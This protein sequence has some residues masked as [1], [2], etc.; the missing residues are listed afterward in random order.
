MPLII[1]VTPDAMVSK[2]AALTAGNCISCLERLRG[3]FSLAPLRTGDHGFRAALCL[4]LPPCAAPELWQTV[5]TMMKRLKVCFVL[6][7]LAV[8]A[9]PLSAQDKVA[10]GEY[11]MS[12]SNNL[13]AKK[14]WV[15]TSRAA[16]GYLLRSEIYTPRDEIR[17]VQVEELSEQLVPASLNFE[18]YLKDHSQADVQVNCGF[19]SGAVSCGGK[20]EKGP[21]ENSA[22]YK[23][24]EAALLIVS[25]LSRFDFGWLAAG[26]VNSAHF[27]SGKAPVR[28]IRLAGG[29]ALELT[30]EINI[31][32][33][34]AVLTANQKFTAVRPEGYTPWQFISSDDGVETL[35]S[36]GTEEVEFAGA[37]LAA[38]HYSL[39]SRGQALHFWMVGPGILL[40]ATMGQN[41]QCVLI[42]YR[43][44][45]KLIPDVKVEEARRD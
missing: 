37:K 43:Q 18:L 8:S 15:L 27:D 3:Y 4:L 29:A 6:L 39:S 2:A 11:Q 22:P 24:K 21:A 32:G 1:V 38:R 16:G 25:E 40:K 13:A 26:M 33:L 45:K 12:P 42:N 19:A 9:L 31:A 5:V 7:V 17:V 44:Y 14:H 36:L 10:E 30:D 28:T 35:V 41:T 23:Y 20:S 34:K